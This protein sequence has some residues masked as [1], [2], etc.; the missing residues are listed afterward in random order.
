VTDYR[1]R[2]DPW[3]ADYESAL[4]ISPEED[5]AADVE[6]GVEMGEWRPVRPDAL[7]HLPRAFFVD[8]VR[9]IEHRLLIESAGRTVFGLLGSAGVGATEAADRA[10]VVESRVRR[11]AV[12]GGGLR[13]EPFEATIG[14]GAGAIL[15]EPEVVPETAP[16]APLQGLQ[17]AMRRAEAALASELSANDA[18]V[19]LD[20]PLSFLEPLDRPIVGF[21]KRLLRPYLLSE[22]ATLLP[23][24]RVGERTPL[25]LIRDAS[26]RASRYSCYLRIG[27]GRAIDAA[28]TGVVRL[29]VSAAMPLAQARGTADT[30][31]ALLPRHAS[32]AARDPR[33]PQNLYPI[34]GLESRLRH[35]LGD[36]LVIR[37]AIERHLHR[38]AVA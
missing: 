38:E 4:Q 18:L 7:A 29:E 2:L 24:L 36:P 21:V 5:G 23:A 28:L 34:G 25:F 16:D 27:S 9:R 12:I 11:L 19:F 22:A 10:R 17:N 33:A 3:S 8:G 20:G 14:D 15:F 30:A 13:I 35:L 6:L 31:A 32:D 37:R 26:G 1:I